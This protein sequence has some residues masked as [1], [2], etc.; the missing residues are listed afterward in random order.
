MSGIDTVV[1]KSSEEPS[2]VVIKATVLNM[3]IA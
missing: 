3:I 2:W 1:L